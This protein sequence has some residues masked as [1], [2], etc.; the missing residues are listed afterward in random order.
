MGWDRFGRGGLVGAAIVMVV[1]GLWL[2]WG[3][4]RLTVLNDAMSVA[5]PSVQAVGAGVAALGAL[6]LASRVRRRGIRW[7]A[8]AVALGALLLAAQRAGYRLEAASSALVSRH[9]GV[10]RR[11]PWR[12]IAQLQVE[13]D[14]AFVVTPDAHR[15][16]VDT[17]LSADE[18][19]IIN[20]TVARRVREAS[21][22]AE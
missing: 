11:L 14:G 6:V 9:F 19:A 4:A 7:V 1:V 18:A 10:T 5:Y 13:P 21:S 22:R 17:G 3:F 8:A 15:I 12:E 16:A 2:A 20:R